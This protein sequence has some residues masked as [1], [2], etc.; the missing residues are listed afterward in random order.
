MIKLKKISI[1]LAI[2][3]IMISCS[4]DRDNPLTSDGTGASYKQKIDMGSFSIALDNDGKVWTWGSNK[5][6]V[7]GKSVE[8]I[9]YSDDPVRVYGMEYITKISAGNSH[10]LALTKDGDVYAWG[11]NSGGQT[12]AG[13]ISAY[14]DVPTKINYLSGV[15]EVYSGDD[16]NFAL[17][18]NG[19]VYSWGYNKYGVL[20]HGIMAQSPT[21]GLV[22]VLDDIEKI[23][24]DGHSCMA[25]QKNGDVWTWGD[26]KNK[27]LGRDDEPNSYEGLK[28][29]TIDGLPRIFDIGFNRQFYVVTEF[30]QVVVID[31]E[32]NK[33]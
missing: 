9:K 8:E 11:L 2:A 3:A 10:C 12:G 32:V 17:L 31:E 5:N 26:N 28:P 16:F 21:P 6:G 33:P 18:K 30:N 13:F 15:K 19:R 24:V 29:G 25:L 1:L 20:G 23:V 4:D 22:L 7:L 14:I 27:R